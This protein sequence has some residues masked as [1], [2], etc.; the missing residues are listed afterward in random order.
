MR[1]LVI[2]HHDAPLDRD[3]LPRWLA[4]ISTYAGTLVVDEPR[5]RIRARARR[6]ITR[7]GWLRFADV[8]AF[9]V[10]HRLASASADRAWE[11]AELERLRARFPAGTPQEPARELVVRSPN[12]TEAEA[13]LRARQPDLV[14]ARCKVL[15]KP[16]VFEIPTFG[17]FAMHPGICP[18]YRNAHGCFW[19]MANGDFDRV[20]MTLLKIDRGV[21]TGA[22]FGYF[23]VEPRARESHVVTQQ[24]A[25]T[26][27]L[28]AIARVLA[29]IEAGAAAPIDTAGRRSAVWGQPWLSAYLRMK[30][31]VDREQL[32]GG[33]AESV[34][35]TRCEL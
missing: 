19:A 24:R 6:E 8:V 12:S 4:T 16:S 9:R 35:R 14:I 17:T 18:E 33:R 3:A 22:V 29:A 11:R 30:L 5:G 20:G 2:C 21:D 13:F 32:T 25:V 10:W 1:T 15:L 27:N 23:R 28:D 31:T 34:D 7:V 26:E